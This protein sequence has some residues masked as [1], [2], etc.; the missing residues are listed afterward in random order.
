MNGL[1]S[2]QVTGYRLQVT[3]DEAKLFTVHCSLFIAKAR[4]SQ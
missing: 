1:T 2:H 4:L 3:V